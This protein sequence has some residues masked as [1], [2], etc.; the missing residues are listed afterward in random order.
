VPPPPVPPE[1]WTAYLT[2]R[3]L[4]ARNALASHPAMLDMVEM[5]LA[6]SFG[7]RVKSGGQ[8]YVCIDGLRSA[9]HAGML[10]GIELFQPDRG[11]KPKTYLT[12][13]IKGYILDELRRMDALDRHDRAANRAVK[14]AVA[15]LEASG[16][17][18]DDEDVAAAAGLTAEQA[19][20]AKEAERRANPASLTT[21]QREDGEEAREVQRA[22]LDPSVFDEIR[23][24]Y[25]MALQFKKPREVAAFIMFH[26]E[27]VGQRELYA[28]LRNK[29][30][31]VSA[32][33]SGFKEEASRIA[34]F[35]SE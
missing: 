14:G 21:L 9:G 22:D 13:K 33:P 10:R 30:R 11:V 35:L 27:D 26:F 29:R 32:P 1:L 2:S 17:E 3:S 31:R 7:G 19:R 15:R 5:V 12:Q 20:L 18:Y 24:R 25:A 8:H 6:A 16:V 28:F 4:T 23:R 34:S